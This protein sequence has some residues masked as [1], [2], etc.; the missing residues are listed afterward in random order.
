MTYDSIQTVA[1]SFAGEYRAQNPFLDFPSAEDLVPYKRILETE[2]TPIVTLV[3]ERL[4]QVDSEGG[5][6]F[7]HLEWV[8][9]FAGY[10]AK[11]ECEFRG[12][13]E[14]LTQKYIRR[15]MLAGL[16]HDVERHHGFG[17][18]H[19]IEGEKTARKF[20][21]QTKLADEAVLLVIKN[22][23]HIDF[24]TA[25]NQ[26]LEIIFGSVFDADHFR[27]GLE[28][29]DTFWRMKEKQGVPVEKVIH[30]YAYLPQYRNAW[31][32]QYGKKIG[33]QLIDFGMAI[34]K[35]VEKTFTPSEKG[36]P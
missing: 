22:H 16:L 21:E 36:T 13:N 28:R 27:Y 18:I 6:G 12:F 4:S 31:R 1:E 11:K 17:E 2:L 20:L 14:I 35:H 32:T 26:D 19:M 23:D 30:D 8:S 24:D 9:F 34:A 10:I 33:P 25:H 15:A 3:Q 7:E 5:H 29:A